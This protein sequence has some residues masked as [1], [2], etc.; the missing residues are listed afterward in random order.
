MATI[1]ILVRPCYSAGLKNRLFATD[2]R[3]SHWNEPYR[4]WKLLGSQRGIE[5]DTWDLHP[6]SSADMIWIQ[7]LPAR[8]RELEDARMQCP[9]TPF[10]Y[11]QYESPIDRLHFFDKRNHDLF[12]AVVTYN[13]QLCEN[14]NDG[15]YHHCHLPIGIPPESAPAVPFTQRRGIVMINQN[16]YCGWLAPRQSGLAGLPVLGP[17]FGGWRLSLRAQR[18]QSSEELYGRRRNIARLAE[19]F[20]DL[21]DVFG[22]GWQGERI[23]W[24]HQLLRPRPFARAKGLLNSPKLETIAQYRFGLA[25]ENIQGDYGYI[26]EKILDVALAGSVPIY[27]GD[28]QIDKIIPA[29]SFVDARQFKSDREMLEFVRDCPQEEWEKKRAA[30]LAFARD[31]LPALFGPQTFAERLLAIGETVLSRRRQP[32]H[33]V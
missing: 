16:R 22:H 12:D 31:Q 9:D 4:L 32:L 8:R 20:G 23:A 17:R 28:N 24:V 21:M 27:L 18:R 10:V 19:Q 15:R 2:S 7:D 6:L 11:L 29:E 14:G 1:R 13:R 5:I 30:A 3:G 25:F 33:S 26:S